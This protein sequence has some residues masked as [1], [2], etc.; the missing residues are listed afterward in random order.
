MKLPSKTKS[1]L[2]YSKI[3]K[4]RIG[5]S[6]KGE[7]LEFILELLS[8]TQ[9]YR[10]VK[11][12]IAEGIEVS[13]V[14]RMV[15]I[16]SGRRIRMFCIEYY[17]DGGFR[18][19]PVSKTKVIDQAFPKRKPTEK[20]KE[21]AHKK[22]KI[23]QVRAALRLAIEDQV[24]ACRRTTPWPYPCKLTGKL[25]YAHDKTHVDHYGKPFVQLVEDWL[26]SEELY[27][28]DLK[29]TGPPTA[30][31]ILGEGMGGV[32]LEDSWKYYHEQYAELEIVSATANISKGAGNNWS[33]TRRWKRGKHTP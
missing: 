21:S 6:I 27:Y 28:S 25:L 4:Q 19:T 23:S 16:A 9:K 12:R 2:Q 8:K 33:K 29:L 13:I 11:E 22:K 31:R 15:E 3:L 26:K 10:F 32:S 18:H 30:K 5:T 7:D 20:Q 14:P 24:K 17:K 1:G